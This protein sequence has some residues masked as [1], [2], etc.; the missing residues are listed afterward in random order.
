MVSMHSSLQNAESRFKVNTQ[1]DFGGET[2]RAK[3]HF[4]ESLFLSVCE[5]IC[6]ALLLH[7]GSSVRCTKWEEFHAPPKFRRVFSLVF[8][9]QC[10]SSSPSGAQFPPLRLS[11]S[12]TPTTLNSN[13]TPRHVEKLSAF[14]SCTVKKKNHP[15]QQNVLRTTTHTHGNVA[16]RSNL[17]SL[18]RLV[19]IDSSTQLNWYKQ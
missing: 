9:F 7:V 17:N 14:G 10:E 12:S 5:R 16:G 18:A 15:K 13:L 6:V 3:F 11:P 1:R 19:T 2:V 4:H 8:F